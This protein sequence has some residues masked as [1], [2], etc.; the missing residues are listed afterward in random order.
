MNVELSRFYHGT[1]ARLPFT[2]RTKNDFRVAEKPFPGR[3]R[4]RDIGFS[5][6]FVS[7]SKQRIDLQDISRRH[8]A[9]NNRENYQEQ[10]ARYECRRTQTLQCET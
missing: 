5:K 3:R 1:F 10:G 2:N 7:Q 4:P 6:L 9:S 8:I